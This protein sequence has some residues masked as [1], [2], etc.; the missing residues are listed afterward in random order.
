MASETA[1]VAVAETSKDRDMDI[2]TFYLLVFMVLIP[3]MVKSMWFNDALKV[4][5]HMQFT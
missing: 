2:K 1:I 5:Y 4:T 3:C